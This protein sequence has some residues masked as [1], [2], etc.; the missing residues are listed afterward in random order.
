MKIR[1]I[2]AVIGILVVV[3]LLIVG[4]LIPIVLYS[5]LSIVSAITLS[6]LLN[7]KGL[8][9][10]FKISVP[11]LLFGLL[12]PLL[13][14]TPFKFIPIFLFALTLFTVLILFNDKV[15]LEDILYLITTS[16]LVVA[17]F[18][19]MVLSCD[20][21]NGLYTSFYVVL[22]LAIPWIA[23]GGAYFTGTFFGKHK[24]CPKIS[25][26]KTVEGAVGGVAAGIIGAVLI[27]I[28]YQYLIYRNVSVNF[29][30]LAVVGIVN[31]VLS[32]IGDLSFSLI[33]RSCHIK[34]YGSVIPGHGG[35]LDRF[36]SVV[37][38]APIIYLAGQYFAFLQ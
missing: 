38:T 12:T 2:S 11:T 4:E 30:L 33:K 31:S 5:V 20:F 23:D 37:F 26:K 36:D 21:H 35:L 9:S 19:C 15:R 8:L 32:I 28:V 18:S 17:C 34:D 24:L 16:V 22:C 3:G 14:T 27:G 13:S 25:P 6:E 7:A 29:V 10:D 1:I